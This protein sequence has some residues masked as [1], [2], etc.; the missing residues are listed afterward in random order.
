M[1]V[2]EILQKI[3]NT[4]RTISYADWLGLRAFSNPPR[5]LLNESD[6][7]AVVDDM[8]L[9]GFTH[10]NISETPMR[11]CLSDD[12]FSYG[13]ILISLDSPEIIAYIEQMYQYKFRFVL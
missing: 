13:K 2:A 12:P 7:P 8:K 5:T 6:F 11:E 10:L 4:S 9:R 3:W 1:T